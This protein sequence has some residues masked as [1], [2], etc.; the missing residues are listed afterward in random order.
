MAT[1]SSRL[2]LVYVQESDQEK[3]I[4]WQRRC[5]YCTSLVGRL[6]RHVAQVLSVLIV[7]LLSVCPGI[8]T[9]SQYDLMV[10]F[11]FHSHSYSMPKVVLL[12]Y[13]RQFSASSS[14]L[15]LVVERRHDY[16][17]STS[18][19]I[20]LWYHRAQVI[21]HR[22]RTTLLCQIVHNIFVLLLRTSSTS[23]N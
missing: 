10:R 13:N 19:S 7:Q 5:P 18:L 6:Q 8:G 9:S 15:Q 20:I 14:K 23:A 17:D 2:F 4:S 3:R 16:P 22:L 21:C 12:R 11:L 1:L